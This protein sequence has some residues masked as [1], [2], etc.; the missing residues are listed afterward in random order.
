V[1]SNPSVVLCLLFA[2]TSSGI[3]MGQEFSGKAIARTP[4]F[5]K[6]ASTDENEK[7]P[8]VFELL[9]NK[10]VF[11]ADGKGSRDLMAR[12]DIK[13]ESAVRELGLLVYPFAYSFESLDIL[14]VRVRKPDGTVIETPA[15][16]MQ[17]LDSAV[18]REAPMYVDQRE[19]HIAVRSLSVGD[20]LELHFHWTLHDPIAP[21]HFWY[22]HSFFRDGACLKEVLE[23][24]VPRDLPVKLRNSKPQPLVHD[25]GSH[26]IYTFQNT[27]LK[28]P[29][30]SKIPDWEK[31]YRGALPP[32]V[33]IS[34]FS[35][36]EEV[37][38]WFSGLA[39]P[40]A[41][42]T[43]EI[44]ARADELIKDKTT[45]EEKMHALYDFVATRF[46]YIGISLGLSRY[47]PHSAAEVLTNRYGDCKDKYTLLAALLQS[48]NIAS[49]PVLISSNYRIDPSFPTPSLFDHVI[50]AIPRGESLLFLDTTPEVAPFG[51][52]LRNLR[53]RQA[54][55]VLTS[56]SSRLISTPAN[57]TIPN[58]ETFR[59]ASSIDTKGTLDG[60]M[61]FEERGDGEI[62]L[63]LAYRATPQ[64]RWQELTQNI[65]ARMGFGGT[66]TDVSVDSPDDTSQPFRF[67]CNYHRP[68]FPDWKNHRITLPAPPIFIRELNEAQKESTDPFPLGSPQDV[69]YEATIRFPKG[70]TAIVPPKEEHKYGFAEFSATYSL[71]E[72]TLHG[73]LHFKTMANEIPAADR[74]KFSNL[75][76]AVEDVESRYILLLSSEFAPDPGM[77]FPPPRVFLKPEDA[78]PQLEQ[79]LE[80]DP[81]N[82]AMVLR[83]SSLYCS[84]GR[85]PDAV[86]LLTK[87]MEAHSDVPAHI[88]VA[89]GKAYLCVPDTEKAIPEFNKALGDDAEPID[90]NETA[91]AL[92]EANTHLPEALAYSMRSVSDLSAKTMD[93][94]PDD[95]EPADFSLMLQLAANWDT[96]G[97]IKFRSGD[98]PGAKKYLQASWEIVQDAVTGEHLVETYEKLGDKRKAAAFC[99]MALSSYLPSRDPATQEKLS[100]EMKRLRPFLSL[101]SKSGLSG[102]SR[103][104][105]PVDGAVALS[106]MRD[107][108]V[109]FRTKLQSDFV[110][111]NFLISI[112]NDR[113]SETVFQSGAKELRGAVAALATLKY[114][115]SFPDDTPTRIIRKAILS[116][117][118]Y[119]TNCTLTLMLATDSA[120]PV[121]VRLTPTPPENPD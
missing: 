76:K 118:S 4:A 95:T 78:I 112:T 10:I 87:T 43:P 25:E 12:V 107:L 85:A 81:D 53:D 70:F 92:A 18:S 28:K 13:S 44:R 46:R 82:D 119:S 62:A 63:R 103:P 98:Y 75:A 9:Q 54:L 56:G 2:F 48:A 14:Y 65:A 116:C 114:P 33:Q 7:E 97:W 45:D 51:F 79:A 99:N 104:A 19:K 83:L 22:D 23:I 115:Q 17:E 31:N 59:I 77:P 113:K 40:K 57:P 50:T 60:K 47:T 8:Y 64:N 102:P 90:L 96:L 49:Y 6:S 37:G 58:Y 29:E 121:P 61:K 71:K 88:H 94:S 30:E 5:A 36:W 3:A 101:S 109:P 110:T 11:D 26:R 35:S 120:V 84:T 105:R 34:S 32:D 66:V 52:L 27:N 38:D 69:L 21:G 108:Q 24:D 93:I 91:Y 86:A 117:S 74:M 55:M 1:R 89:L 72:D 39:Q 111:A 68:D 41:V 100:G 20:V 42:V 16:D 80:A 15:S 73:T 67:S 106:E